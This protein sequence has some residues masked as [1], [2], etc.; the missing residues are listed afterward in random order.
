MNLST[1][2][3][4]ELVQIIQNGVPG[5]QHS[6]QAILELVGRKRRLRK[7]L[8][9]LL[10]IDPAVPASSASDATRIASDTPQEYR[11]RSRQRRYTSTPDATD[12]IAYGWFWNLLVSLIG[13]ILSS[14]IFTIVGS[15]TTG[16]PITAT[17]YIVSLSLSLY[18][19]SLSL[20]FI[21][22]RSLF[23]S[24]SLILLILLSLYLLNLIL[25]LSLYLLSLLSLILLLL[26]VKNEPDILDE[27]RTLKTNIAINAGL[28]LGT[29]IW[30]LL[31]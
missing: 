20:F 30:T 17:G 23:F 24:L 15:Q 2:T 18:L 3:P 22:S 11:Q 12:T 25:L 14:V 1:K 8:I 9:Y 29:L 16:L 6:R 21:L 5:S 27:I 19:I 31:F 7:E 28:V 10:G 26:S 13:I 4:G